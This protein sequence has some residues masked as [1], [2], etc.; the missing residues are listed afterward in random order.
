MTISAEILSSFRNLET[1]DFKIIIKVNNVTPLSSVNY[2]HQAYF[3]I[4]NIGL[5][6]PLLQSLNG[7]NFPQHYFKV[8]LVLP[9]ITIGILIVNNKFLIIPSDN[10]YNNYNNYKEQLTQII[11]NTNSNLSP[12]TLP[13]PGM[14]QNRF[15]LLKKPMSDFLHNADFGLVN[16]TLP[17]SDTNP[18][19]SNYI[20][21]I[22]DGSPRDLVFSILQLY[23][24]Y[25]NLNIPQ[26]VGRINPDQM[27]KMYFEPQ[28]EVI[29][30]RFPK[31]D[32]NSM[33][34]GEFT[35]LIEFN[36]MN[37]L[38]TVEEIA[39]YNFPHIPTINDINNVM[40]IINSTYGLY[41]GLIN[42]ARNMPGITY[43]AIDG[44]LRN[45][46]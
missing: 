29:R 43:Y 34:I 33:S 27:M 24:I 13:N 3:T 26:N 2:L 37:N 11:I 31:F 28:V 22:A 18:P 16:P 20:K 32:L 14:Y 40:S 45:T 4:N 44:S 21:L 42:Q 39:E 5:L 30:R 19:L 41:N 35:T 38:M 15:I 9:E 1:S 8:A 7:L 23:I 10:N 46:S 6:A 17:P 36:D 12:V 25:N